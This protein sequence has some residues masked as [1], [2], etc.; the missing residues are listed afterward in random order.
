MKRK[1][2]ESLLRHDFR[3]MNFEELQK[4]RVKLIDAIRESTAEYG[5]KTAVQNGFYKEIVS[6]SATGYSPV[7]IWLTHNLK[8][9]YTQVNSLYTKMLTEENTSMRNIVKKAEE[10]NFS[11]VAAMLCGKTLTDEQKK[12]VEVF[13][14]QYDAVHKEKAH[15]N[16]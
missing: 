1:T 12:D 13:N 3:I 2:A 11:S 14:V 16:I 8:E 6:E 9:R 10:I 7:N 4:Y 15:T 5:Y